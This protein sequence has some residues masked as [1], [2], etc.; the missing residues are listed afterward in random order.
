[1]TEEGEERVAK[2]KGSGMRGVSDGR[3]KKAS[4]CGGWGG[5]SMKTWVGHV[6]KRSKIRERLVLR[7]TRGTAPVIRRVSIHGVMN[8]KRRKG[9]G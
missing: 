6:P 2:M 4:L 8:V 5:M 7:R 3:A 1:L 9:E